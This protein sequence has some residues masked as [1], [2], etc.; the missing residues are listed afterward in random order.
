[1]MEFRDSARYPFKGVWHDSVRKEDVPFFYGNE[2][3]E[4]LSIVENDRRK[5]VKIDKAIRIHGNLLIIPNDKLK[6]ADGTTL[7]V[8]EV[9]R[10]YRHF[11]S[12]VSLFVKPMV[13]ETVAYLE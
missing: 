3:E 2:S 4:H 7:K 13:Q 8:S 1:M 6:L 10:K 11:N 12:V 5:I 9:Y